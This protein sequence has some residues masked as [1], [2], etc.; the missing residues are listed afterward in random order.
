MAAAIAPLADGAV[1]ETETFV[2]IPYVGFDG[3]AVANPFAVAR[4]DRLP[5]EQHLGY[6]LTWWGLAAA[7]VAIYFAVHVNA[8]RLRFG[9]GGG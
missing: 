4:R 6:A 1:V 8:G 7:L 3:R 2:A 5:P 9:R